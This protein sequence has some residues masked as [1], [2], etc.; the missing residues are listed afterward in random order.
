V[1]EATPG[2]DG[3]RIATSVILEQLLNA[4]PSDTVTLAW[5]IGALRQRSFGLVM[6]LMALVALVPGGST[7][8]GVLLIFPAVQMILARES[9]SLPRFIA[10]RRIS[11]ARIARV[12]LRAAAF[13]RWVETFS[14]PRW[15]TPFQATKRVVG[16]VV[17]LLAPTLVW[18][19]PFS[20]IIPA[21]VIMLLALAYLEEDGVLLCV[22]LAAALVSL[23]IT[24]ATV[25]AG[26][27]VTD[28]L[29]PL[30]NL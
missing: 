3:A 15:Q 12:S 19:F 10:S 13:L 21:L 24:A 9:P 30:F 14:K 20:Q 27:K 16:F 23:A 17:L 4:A 25:W 2:Q 6:L 29:T 26:I 18:P 1:G 11:T 22:A 5:L 7:V 8:I 28:W